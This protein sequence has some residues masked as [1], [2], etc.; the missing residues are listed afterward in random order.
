MEK[1]N[2]AFSISY[3]GAGK[4]ELEHFKIKYM[5]G[6]TNEKMK[7]LRA[8]DKNVDLFSTLI[9]VIIGLIGSVAVVYGTIFIIKER[10]YDLYGVLMLVAGL[11]VVSFVPV[12]HSRVYAFVKD[13]YAPKILLLIKEIEENKI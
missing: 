2:N 13:F 1:E 8:Y 7:K 4:E 3:S 5:P 9:S 12:F 6:N 10:F 11:L